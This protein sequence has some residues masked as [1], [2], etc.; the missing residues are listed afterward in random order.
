M[1][2][3]IRKVTRDLKSRRK[4]LLE[5]YNADDVH[6]LRVN[7]RRIRGLLKHQHHNKAKALRGDWKQLARQTNAARDW[8]TFALYTSETAA[9]DEIQQLL[10]LLQRYQKRSRRRVLRALRSR[11]WSVTF[12]KWKSHLRKTDKKQKTHEKSFAKPSLVAR[13]ESAQ[14]RAKEARYQALNWGDE[15]SW[16]RFRIAIKDLRYTLDNH[17][18]ESDEQRTRIKAAIRLCRQLQNAL[19][20]WHDTV[21]HRQLLSKLAEDPQ[22]QKEDGLRRAINAL[23]D[24]IRTRADACLNRVTDTLDQNDTILDREISGCAAKKAS[25]QYLDSC[26]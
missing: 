2:K 7:I 4:A 25:N 6:Q 14:R 8:D 19:G 17:D 12:K 26:D 18:P 1:T 20:D 3:K 11:E 5:S 21:V 15:A 16:H 13:I 22:V 24:R 23:G 10:P 9:T